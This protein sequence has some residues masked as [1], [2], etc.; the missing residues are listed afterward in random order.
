MSSIVA[1]GIPTI[2]RADL[3]HEAME[4]YQE[5]WKDRHFFIVDNGN[6]N[7]QTNQKKQRVMKMPFNL[8]VSGS[9]NLMAKTAFN[10]GY[11]HIAILNDDI[12]FKKEAYKIE[13]YIDKH[14]ADFYQGLG[15][16]CCFI[17]PYTTWEKIGGFD[18]KFII[19]YFEDNDYAYRMKLAG[20]K[21]HADGWFNPEV[22]RNSQTIAKDNSLN[23]QFE[24]NKQRFI[25]KWGGFPT[26]E[27][28]TIPFNGVEGWENM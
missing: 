1:L 20:L 21:V 8:G 24:L 16:W 27:T 11:T 14:P 3:L 6:Q 7:I 17:L 18:E 22:Y 26:E 25:N 10:Q 5:T 23:R 12:I 19:G 4:V 9:W 2:N 28:Y 15:T 13:D